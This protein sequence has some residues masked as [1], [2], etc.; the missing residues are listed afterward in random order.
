MKLSNGW[1]VTACAAVLTMTLASGISAQAA[2]G[3]GEDARQFAEQAMMANVA[4]VKLGQLAEQRAQ[5]AAVKDFARTMVRDHTKGKNDLK[6]A[7]KGS[8][9]AE[10]AQL[11]AKHQE[12]YDRLS[13]LNGAEFDREYM[14][15]MAAGHGEVK[16]MLESRAT[17]SSTA[18]KGTAGSA[19]E[20]LDAAVNDWAKKALP[21]VSQHLQKAEQIS[22]Q[23]NK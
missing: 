2:R 21:T 22:S 6:Q 15:A 5:N 1:G 16:A 18:T 17:T 12:L 7:V 4:E 13:K 11:D 14:K 8:G 3:G 23:V 10:P 9:I 20:H 19:S